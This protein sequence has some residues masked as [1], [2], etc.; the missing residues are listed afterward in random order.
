MS[1]LTGKSVIV[2]SMNLDCGEYQLLYFSGP[3]VD[4]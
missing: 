1:I 4:H 3:L 2:I